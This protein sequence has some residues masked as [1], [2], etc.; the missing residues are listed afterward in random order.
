MDKGYVPIDVPSK[1]PERDDYICV[2]KFS[3]DS[4]GVAYRNILTL[5]T[6]LVFGDS[7][8]LTVSIGHGPTN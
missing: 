5:S 3:L 8:S 2:G 1:I 6:L 7:V 4:K